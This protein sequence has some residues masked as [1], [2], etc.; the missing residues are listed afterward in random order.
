MESLSRNG[1]WTG[2]S[3]YHGVIRTARQRSQPSTRTHRESGRRLAVTVPTVHQW[4]PRGPSTRAVWGR[5]FRSPARASVIARS[6]PSWRAGS[7]TTAAPGSPAWPSIARRRQA[8]AMPGTPRRSSFGGRA[9]AAPRSGSGSSPARATAGRADRR[10]FPS[11]SWARTRTS[12]APPRRCRAP[13]FGSARLRPV[14]FVGHSGDSVGRL[15]QRECSRRTRA[16]PGLARAYRMLIVNP[17]ARL[18]GER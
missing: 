16:V 1:T 15:S 8:G 12:S 11:A 7:P 13:T 9:P 6:S 3:Q 4:M 5:R 2:S 14:T 10:S 18:R 17:N